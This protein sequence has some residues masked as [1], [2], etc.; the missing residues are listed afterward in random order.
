MTAYNRKK[1]LK[2]QFRRYWSEI[3]TCLDEDDEY[4]GNKNQEIKDEKAELER[5][6]KREYYFDNAYCIYRLKIKK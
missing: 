2:I 3:K 4:V 6:F 1:I 5:R